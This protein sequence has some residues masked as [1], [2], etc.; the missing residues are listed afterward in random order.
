MMSR[1][2]LVLSLCLAFSWICSAQQ[3]TDVP[4]SKEDVERYFQ[5]AHSRE[6]VQQVL[7]SMS[8][9]MHEIVHEQYIKDGDKLPPDF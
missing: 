7:D 4:A 8:Q 6:L 5:V 2:F 3:T 1:L 9:S